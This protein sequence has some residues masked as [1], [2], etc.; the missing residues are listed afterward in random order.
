MIRTMKPLI[1]LT[2]LLIIFSSGVAQIIT[3]NDGN[4][5]SKDTSIANTPEAQLMVRTGDIDNLGFGWPSGFD[6]F[7]G[8]N[9]PSH[10]Y[11]WNP[12][13][14]DPAGTDRIMV[15]TSYNG[16]APAG[17]DGYTF[18]TSRPWNAVSPIT[19]NFSFTG[20]ITHAWLY[21][22]L[23][24]FQA[25]VW[26]ASYQVS[27]D[28]VRVPLYESLVNSLVQTGPIGKIV[29]LPIP[30]NLLYLLDDGKLQI[31]FD[32]YTTGAGDGYAIDFV[33]L[34]INPIDPFGSC[35]LK[36]KVT[37]FGTGTPLENVKVLANGL[38]SAFTDANGNYRVVGV[39]PGIILIQT[40]KAGY[41][42]EKVTLTLAAT[43][44][45]VRNFELRTGA[46]QLVHHLPAD[47]AVEVDLQSKIRMVFNQPINPSTFNHS[48]FLLSDGQS[49]LSG[50]YQTS[51]DTLIFIPNSLTLGKTYQATVTTN[52]KSTTGVSTDRNYNFKFYT[53]NPLRI[54]APKNVESPLIF[55]NPSSGNIR[56]ENMGAFQTL[57]IYNSTGKEVFMDKIENS[58]LEYNLPNFPKGIY[59]LRFTGTSGTHTSRLVLE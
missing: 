53:Y 45:A 15:I 35:V 49:D 58:K 30:N 8:L 42:A 14:A 39:N 31:R 57:S 13:P 36:G 6:P 33:K 26:Q 28:S 20:T 56:L 41:G 37:E 40:Y 51:G 5:A 27:L 10:P 29:K 9:T 44:S 43:D 7:S 3:P 11:P 52:L 48:S 12:N 18:G 46:P 19:L 2:A 32:D 21:A 17:T 4:W 16:N 50:L 34:L 23:D 47:E 25:P 59:L 54:S 55:P 22:F 38:D 1:L 24:D